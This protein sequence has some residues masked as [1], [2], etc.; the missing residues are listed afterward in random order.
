MNQGMG[1][2]G[3]FTLTAMLLVFLMLAILVTLDFW[4]T[5]NVREMAAN[6]N[7]IRNLSQ[8]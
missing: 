8:R 2:H 5:K 1:I 7:T 4:E 3:G 6:L